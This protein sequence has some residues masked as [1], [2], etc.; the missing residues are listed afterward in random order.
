MADETQ[1][2]RRITDAMPSFLWAEGRAAQVPLGIGDDAMVLRGPGGKDWV[3]STDQFVEAVHFCSDKHSPDSVGYKALARATSDLAAMGARPRFFLLDLGLPASRTGRW[4]EQMLGGMGRSARSL[5][6]TLVGGD[7]TQTSS[8]AMTFT[9][10]GEIAQGRAVTRTG[11]RPGDILYVS[12]TLGRAQFGL[13]LMRLAV[14]PHQVRDLGR[15]L[16]AHLYPQIHIEL[17]AWL[18]RHRLASGMMDLSDG[19]SSD[20]ARLCRASRVGAQVFS[21]AIPCVEMPS[22][23]GKRIR[24]RFTDPLSMALHGGDDYELLFAIPKRLIPKLGGAPGFS[25]LRAIGE[26]RRGRG[27]YLVD[28]HRRRRPLTP[29]GWDPFRTKS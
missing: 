14:A 5:G 4:L 26:I 3:I 22:S 10:I 7:T 11:A 6:L 20:L 21:D 17:G 24:T 28:A 13:E 12:G 9:V 18:A 27:V 8:I 25:D 19:L 2:I 29:K 16:E 23:V 15:L 1:L